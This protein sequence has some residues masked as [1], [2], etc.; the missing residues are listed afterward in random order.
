MAKPANISEADTTLTAPGAVI[1]P[2]SRFNKFPAQEPAV[3]S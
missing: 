3:L 1:R 2:S